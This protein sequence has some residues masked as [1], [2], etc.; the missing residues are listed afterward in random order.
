MK[1]V[2]DANIIIAALIKESKTR[3]ILK[4]NKFEFISPE[5][6]IEETHKYRTVICKKAG[7]TKEIFEMLMD[8][9]FE[10]IKI[11]NNE[12]YKQWIDT[13]KELIS[14]KKD[15]PYVACYLALKCAGIWTNDEDFKE[16]KNI[17]VFK[18]QDM[19]DLLNS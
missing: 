1:I 11:I 15:V 19:L 5:F 2:I 16:N 6:I 9:I 17:K 8:L 18:T 3:E 13:A 14:D 7:I 4:N 10:N 12:E